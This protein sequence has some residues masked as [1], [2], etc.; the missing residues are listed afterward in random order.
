MSSDKARYSSLDRILDILLMFGESQ[1]PLSVQRL[2]EAFRSS[3]S[4]TYRY[5]QILRKRGL[6]EEADVPGHFR[7]GPM[8]LRLARTFGGDAHLKSLADP[9]LQELAAEFGESVMLT[10][11][12]GHSV[13][14]LSS[15]DSP[16]IIRVNIEA[17]NNSPLHVGSFGKLH[18]AYIDAREVDRYLRHPLRAVAPHTVTDPA[19][20]RAELDTT[21]AQGYAL[22]DSEVEPGMRSLSVPVLDEGGSL[23]A[24]LTLAGPAFRMPLAPLRRHAP[25]LMAAAAQIA[26]QWSMTPSLPENGERRARPRR[27]SSH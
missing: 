21:R 23:M 24:V 15:I 9:I 14:V 1:G 5:V 18:L 27:L 8:V 13:L 10:R 3:R 11:R 4:S 19:A 2:S 20:L 16:Q 12:S 26:R 7:L 6:V 22:S 25:R 17:A